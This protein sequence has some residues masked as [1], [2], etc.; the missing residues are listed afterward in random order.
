[1]AL[2]EEAKERL[3]KEVYE[4]FLSWCGDNTITTKNILEIGK[5]VDGRVYGDL[6]RMTKRN[7]FKDMEGRL[8]GRELLS[9]WCNL[10]DPVSIIS[11]IFSRPKHTFFTIFI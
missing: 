1:M 3:G 4:K 2:A 10:K 11:R 5:R 6:Q 8:F 7:S 9:R